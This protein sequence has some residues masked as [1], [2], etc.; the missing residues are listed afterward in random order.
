MSTVRRPSLRPG[1]ERVLRWRLPE[2]DGQP[3]AEIGVA[4]SAAGKVADGTV[5][6][7]YLRWD[8]RAGNDLASSRQFPIDA[9]DGSDFWRMAWVNGASLFSKRFP[10]SFRIS[11]NTGEGIIL[12]GTRQWTDYRVRSVITLHLGSYGGVAVRAQGMRRY[13]AARLT[14]GGP[15]QIVRVRDEEVRVLAE[16]AVPSR[17]G[18]TRR[19]HR[20]GPGRHAS[21][22]RRTAFGWSPRTVRSPTAPL[23]YWCTKAP[24]PH[25]RSRWERQCDILQER[26]A[27][28]A[29][30][31][32]ENVVKSYG[33]QR[34]LHGVSIE[35]RGR[36]VRGAGRSI[37]LR[38]VHAAPDDR[39]ARGHLR[40]DD[41]ASAG[42]R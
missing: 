21:R 12:H 1:E 27:L 6:V 18:K 2:F 23:G 28:M 7:D 34:V 10:P 22:L 15:F 36:I 4:W 8:G 35:V 30:V 41:H 26:V 38:Q 37:R 11:Q 39:R 25:L 33:G 5:S 16:T 13:Y 20:R 29:S 3:I 31:S 24:C 19:R 14:R 40:R 32:I 17:T 9:M 42:K